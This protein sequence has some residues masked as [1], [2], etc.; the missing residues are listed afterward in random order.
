MAWLCAV[1]TQS[2]DVAIEN[3]DQRTQV[4]YGSVCEVRRFEE[5]MYGSSDR[6][7]SKV[8]A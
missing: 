2:L 1:G 3:Y 5:Y 4:C 7:A 6:F 8:A